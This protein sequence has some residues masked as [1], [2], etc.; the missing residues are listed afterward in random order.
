LTKDKVNVPIT[1]WNCSCTRLPNYDSCKFI[2]I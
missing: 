2:I 1:W